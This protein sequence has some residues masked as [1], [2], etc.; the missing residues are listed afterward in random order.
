MQIKKDKPMIEGAIFD[1]DGTILDSMPIWDQA[2]AIFLSK[3]GI[4]AEKNLGEKMLAMSMQEGAVY[5]KQNYLLNMDE[6]EIIAGIN[7]AIRKFYDEEVPLK[8]NVK[9]FLQEIKQGG[10]QMVAAT[11]SDRQLVEGALKRLGVIDYFDKIFTCTEIGA[12]KDKPDIYLAG[13]SYM[14]TAP[15]NTWVFE[16]ALHAIQTANKAG[17]KTVGVFDAASIKDL[18]AIK[19]AS[20]IY[21]GKLK[22]GLDENSINNCRK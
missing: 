7:Q 20:H 11:A 17:F 2:G 18:Q 21:L 15:E 8:E 4:E 14:G 22:G 3:L 13:S 12:G 6:E 19:K 5:L 10:I 16:D 1:I 9:Q